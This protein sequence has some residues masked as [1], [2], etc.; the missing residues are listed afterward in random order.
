VPQRSSRQPGHDRRVARGNGRV[1]RGAGDIEAFHPRL[2]QGQRRQPAPWRAR[3]SG[4]LDGHGRQFDQVG[5]MRHRIS[6]QRF[7]PLQRGSRVA[8]ADIDFA[9][10]E[11]SG[12]DS[13]IQA[14]G[15]GVF[16]GF[17][18]AAAGFGDVSV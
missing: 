11:D 7:K 1:A 9:V 5:G 16:Q 13:K 17:R 15:D 14:V 3:E 18:R 4:R 6:N 10:R 12:A 2:V 8:E